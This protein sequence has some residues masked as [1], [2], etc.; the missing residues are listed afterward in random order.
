MVGKAYQTNKRPVKKRVFML[1]CLNHKEMTTILP[2][3]KNIM[4][5]PAMFL[6]DIHE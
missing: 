3:C 4:N 6:K 2:D 1:A 5:S